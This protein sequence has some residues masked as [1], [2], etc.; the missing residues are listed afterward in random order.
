M[1]RVDD[2]MMRLT[3]IQNP[4]TGIG[5]EAETRSADLKSGTGVRALVKRSATRQLLYFH[6][7]ASDRT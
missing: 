5:K 2:G 4:R 1:G 7:L 6:F 3:V